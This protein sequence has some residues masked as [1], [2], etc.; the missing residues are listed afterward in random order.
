MNKL[1]YEGLLVI[2]G[3]QYVCEAGIGKFGPGFTLAG[4]SG[5]SVGGGGGSSGGG[6]TFIRDA[7]MGT[8]KSIERGEVA[9]GVYFK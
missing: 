2:N 7:I 5:G 1:N 9:N 4:Y 6:G 8:T 3:G